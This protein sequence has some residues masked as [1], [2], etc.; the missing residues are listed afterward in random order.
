MGGFVVMASHT[1]SPQASGFHT[2]QYADIVLNK[3]NVVLRLMKLGYDVLLT[4]ADI[5]YLRNPFNFFADLPVCDLYVAVESGPKTYKKLTTPTEARYSIVALKQFTFSIWINTGFVY[6]KNN[7]DTIQMVKEFLKPAYRIP[8]TDD[9]QEFNMFLQ[10]R[11][12]ASN[13]RYNP[14]RRDSECSLIS[15]N[16]L[17][18]HY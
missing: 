6:F 11:K 1:F 2:N 10:N 4:D 7:K 17:F 3:W 5:V 16:F 8:G 18:F 15:G 14:N 13:S 9:Q 12:T